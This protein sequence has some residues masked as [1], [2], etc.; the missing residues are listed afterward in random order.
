MIGGVVTNVFFRRDGETVVI[1]VVD[2]VRLGDKAQIEVVRDS[3][4]EKIWLGDS[5]WWQGRNAHWTAAN[6]VWPR[7]PHNLSLEIGKDVDVVL[8]KIGPSK[9]L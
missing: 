6:H 5:V 3:E 8:D 4:S 2:R 7:S 9:V 1:D